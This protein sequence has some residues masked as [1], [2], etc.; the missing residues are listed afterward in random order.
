MHSN[1]YHKY[2]TL[3]ISIALLLPFLAFSQQK[4][5]I[6]GSIINSTGKP[7]ENVSVTLK[8]TKYGVI[9]NSEG[10]YSFKAP[11]GNYILVISHV[12]ISNRESAITIKAGQVTGMPLTTIN[13]SVNS[14]SEVNINSSKTNR[15]YKK[16]SDGVAKTPLDNLENPQV[17]STITSELLTQQ[18][19]TTVDDALKNAPGVQTMWQATG[20]SGD[21]GG[22]YNMR[23]FITQS[24]FR[25]GIAG[26]ISNTVDAANLQSIE[27]IK[28]PSATLFGSSLTSYGGLINRITKKPYDTVGGEVDYQSGSYGLNRAAL[29]LNTPLNAQK[30]LLFRLNTAYTSKGSYMDNGFSR[31]LAVDPTLTY[32]ASDRLSFQLDAEI[33]TGRNTIPPI[34]FFPYG[35][36]IADLG[37]SRADQL[38]VNYYRSYS[39]GDLSQRSV[40][41]NFYGQMNYK[42]SDNW[43]SQTNISSTYSYSNGFG[44]YFYLLPGDSIS[45]N[46]QSTKNSYEKTLEIQENINGDF[47]IAGLRNRFVGGLDFFRINSS[48]YFLGATYDDAPDNSSTFNYNALNKANLSAFENSVNPNGYFTYPF[49]FKSNTYSAYASDVLNITDQL[50][51]LAAIRFD[52]F[53]NKGNYNPDTKV[54]TGLFTQNAFSPKFGLVYQ[55]LKDK[56][57][58]F[59]N[60]QNGFTNQTASTFGGKPFKPEEANQLEG[61]VKLNALEGKLTGTLS[62]YDIK[63][64]DIL[65]PDPEHANFSIQNGTQVSKGFEAEV[66]ANPFTGF[67]IIAGFSYNDS[68]YTNADPDVNGLRPG[69]AASPYT[70]NFW[71]SYRLPQEMIKGLGF[72]FGGN[73][74]S[75]NKVINTR[76]QGVFTLPAYTL[77]NANAF[78]D[79]A[80]YRVSFGV[81]NLTDKRYWTGYSTVNPQ[82]PIQLVG[83]VAFKF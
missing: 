31:T 50:L 8:G 78:Y 32:K 41:D 79:I 17:Y 42:I 59:A 40:S 76:S 68:K 57:S 22:Y 24:Q 34:F 6:K 20:R 49:Y 25:N 74:A 67:N 48:Q 53:D 1:I 64:N 19:I 56:V 12:G 81:N 80:K 75:D 46:D 4:G 2:L 7:A 60:Y 30:N 72:G 35:K 10:Q 58:L 37:Y 39:N 52:H 82:M 47:K 65:R 54:S 38:P 14:L 27:I 18:N 70:A 21:G 9:T 23:G 15:F 45:R 29:D 43:K 11:A 73:Y 55:V 5:T 83:T 16:H 66:I 26:G 69:T 71:L 44:P 61:G 62:Y 77:L 36:T 51:A 63:V 3:L 13:E 28:G 33:Y